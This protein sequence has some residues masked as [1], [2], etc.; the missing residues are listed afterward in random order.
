MWRQFAPK[1]AGVDFRMLHR[2][3]IAVVMPAYRAEKTL[4]RTYQDIPLDV[5]DEVLLV[6]DASTDQTLARARALGVRTFVH[7]RNL[8]YGANQKTCYR[9]A[10][11]SGADVVVMLHPDYQ[12]DPRLITPMAGMVA[13]GVYD[14]VL[15]SRILG[16][17]ALRGGMPLYKYF[18]N[19]CLTLVQN[20]L[21]GAKVSEYHTGYRAF[22]REVLCNLPLL[23][24][25]DDFVFDNEMLAQAIAAGFRLGEISCPTKY[26]PEASS[27]SFRRS[28]VYGFGVLRTSL[29]FRL[30]K[31]KWLKPRLFSE[32]P[33]YRLG[34]GYYKSARDAAA[35]NAAATGGTALGNAPPEQSAV[36]ASDNEPADQ[37]SS[38]S[39]V[40]KT[41]ELAHA[42]S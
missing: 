36:A 21:L 16:N 5:V 3:K 7:C 41:A 28:M 17:S 9:E 35:T 11:E 37:N 18:F 33:T 40:A 13:S 12:Y 26:F 8:G 4:E 23:A 10:L 14:L 34:S 2:K 22:S 24:N 29:L 6:D 25:S 30:W 42:A 31:W 19:R 15:G 38:V 20:L 27:I 39:G 1:F 32:S